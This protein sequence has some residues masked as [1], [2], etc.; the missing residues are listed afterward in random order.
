M[1]DEDIVSVGN[2]DDEEEFSV[3]GYE[4]VD[5]L[6]VVDYDAADDGDWVDEEEV[7]VEGAEEGVK[8]GAE[9]RDEERDEEVDEEVDV[10]GV[11]EEE[12]D[13]I[14]V[15]DDDEAPLVDSMTPRNGDY[16]AQLRQLEV[17]MR[18]SRSTLLQALEQARIAEAN[19]QQVVDQYRNLLP[20]AQRR[21]FDTAFNND[22]T[23]N[24]LDSADRRDSVRRRT[25]STRNVDRFMQYYPV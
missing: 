14:I 16:L 19:Y 8:E 25:N 22:Q 7:D 15:I 2:D 20:P 6:L 13:E 5:Q 1:D 10:D 11:E 17:T 3:V 21:T 9:E 12:E 23:G 4:D 18:Q 24:Y